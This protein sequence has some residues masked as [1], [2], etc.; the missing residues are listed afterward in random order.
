MAFDMKPVKSSNIDE[1]GY[2]P[3]SETLRIRYKNGGVYDYHGV[4]DKLAQ[5]FEDAPSAGH[6]AATILRDHCPTS[7]VKESE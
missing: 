7:K 2:E 5:A 1:A 3:E 6:F 4:T